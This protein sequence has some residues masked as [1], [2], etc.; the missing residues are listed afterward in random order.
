[1]VIQEAGNQINLSSKHRNIPESMGET[2][3][4]GSQM[5]VIQERE[6]KRQL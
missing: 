6:I 2:K 3:W 4:T 5:M 1:M